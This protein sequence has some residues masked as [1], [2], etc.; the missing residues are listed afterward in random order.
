MPLKKI[1]T[2]PITLETIIALKPQ[3]ELVFE[4]ICE[5]KSIVEEAKS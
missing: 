3:P 5:E 4:K 1:Q 2:S